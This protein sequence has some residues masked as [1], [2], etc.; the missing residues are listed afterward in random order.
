MKPYYFNLLASVLGI[1]SIS[2]A[3]E[4]NEPIMLKAGDS[5][6]QVP[7]PGWAFP[8]WADVDG[9]GKNELI[10]GQFNGGKMKVYQHNGDL[11]FE[12]GTWL[13]ADGQDAQVPGVW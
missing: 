9:D 3:A 5:P 10:V 2:S 8:E 4:F 12:S 1:F 11:K 7:V 6:I 13:Q